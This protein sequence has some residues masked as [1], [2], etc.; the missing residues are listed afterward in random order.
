MLQVKDTRCHH[1]ACQEAISN[2]VLPPS[3]S[4]MKQGTLVC[5]LRCF[6]AVQ[7]A[8]DCLVALTA[9]N[10]TCL[11][12]QREPGVRLRE[13][14]PRVSKLHTDTHDFRLAHAPSILIQLAQIS[15]WGKACRQASLS[16]CA[17]ASITTIN[18]LTMPSATSPLAQ[19]IQIRHCTVFQSGYTS[20]L[21][22]SHWSWLGRNNNH[23]LQELQYSL[24]L[25]QMP[26]LYAKL[27][28]TSS[29]DLQH[30]LLQ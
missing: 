19:G 2:A 22:T 28:F 18:Q 20:K 23:T 4:T 25:M 15:I 16:A 1:A 17:L 29:V 8:V 24:F 10:S 26:R 12:Q 14:G 7:H 5:F 21:C 6:N 13:H 3:K 30:Q 9:L 27:Q 11:I